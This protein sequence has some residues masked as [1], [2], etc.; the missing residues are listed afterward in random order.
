MGAFDILLRA[1]MCV[2]AVLILGVGIWM[3]L[4]ALHNKPV[5]NDLTDK[6]GTMPLTNRVE[7]VVSRSP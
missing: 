5:S 1:L 2:I 3:G 4:D 6:G 7:H